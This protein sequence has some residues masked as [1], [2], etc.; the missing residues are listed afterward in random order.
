LARLFGQ[1]AKKEKLEKRLAA[2]R[3]STPTEETA[4]EIESVVKQINKASKLRPFHY[5]HQGSLAYIG[6]EKA[7]ADLPFL[8]GNVSFFRFHM[9]ESIN[10]L[11]GSLRVVVWQ[12]TCSGVRRTSPICSRCATGYWSSM[13]GSRLKS[14]DGASCV[15]LS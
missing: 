1:I 5:S 14:L 2:L 15:L 6:S 8:N 9:I 11:A 3:A 4:S 7:I 12:R 10:L 13:T